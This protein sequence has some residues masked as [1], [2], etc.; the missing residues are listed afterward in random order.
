MSEQT[1]AEV[2]VAYRH[3]LWKDVATRC[4]EAV[5]SLELAQGLLEDLHQSPYADQ[6]QPL[7]D[8]IKRASTEASEAAG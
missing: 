2:E 7:I 6:L 1:E 8:T 5:H 4:D 3:S